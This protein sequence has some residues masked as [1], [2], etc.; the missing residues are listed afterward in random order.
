MHCLCPKHCNLFYHTV[1]YYKVQNF[2][3]F[4]LRHCA[5]CLWREDDVIRL[6]PCYGVAKSVFQNILFSDPFVDPEYLYVRAPSSK[7]KCRLF[8]WLPKT[9]KIATSQGKAN[10]DKEFEGFIWWKFIKWKLKNVSGNYQI[11]LCDHL[12]L[13]FCLPSFEFTIKH[14]TS[15]K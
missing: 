5:S 2:L 9:H 11:Q 3:L 12:M 10:I 13:I 1:I 8:S 7:R 6:C 14:F 15:C 4:N